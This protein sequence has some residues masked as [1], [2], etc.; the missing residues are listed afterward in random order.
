VHF[1]IQTTTAMAP[2]AI[3][4]MAG[5]REAWKNLP[6]PTLYPVKEARF[7]KY[8]PPQVDGHERALAQPDGQASI[9]IDNGKTTAPAQPPGG[10]LADMVALS[11]R[12]LLGSGRL[13]L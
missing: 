10:N 2:S 11:D 4:D 9:I 7:E 8:V 5:R 3:D 12:L 6:L 13:V 1:Y